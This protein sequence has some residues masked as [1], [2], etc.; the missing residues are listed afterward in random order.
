MLL[1]YFFQVSVVTAQIPLAKDQVSDTVVKIPL[2][3]EGRKR[4]LQK[5]INR[6]DNWTN[7]ASDNGLFDNIQSGDERFEEIQSNLKNARDCLYSDAHS[8]TERYTSLALRAY[9]KS[10]YSSSTKWRFS[11]IYA[12]PMWIYLIGFLIS[13]LIFYCMQLDGT[14]LKL[15]SHIEATA[16][17]ATTWGAVGGILRGLWYLKDKVSDR[18]YRNSFQIYFLSVPFLGALFGALV[19]LLFV[20][21][22]FILIP[23][24]VQNV[25]QN[26]TTTVVN[27]S[28]GGP[29]TFTAQHTTGTGGFV[30]KTNQSNVPNQGISTVG[31]IFFSALGGFNWEWAVTIIKR[32]GDSFK[33]EAEPDE[34]VD[35]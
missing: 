9:D 25:L 18:K 24:Q 19:Y 26:Q 12:G 35:R 23:G 8:D 20:A 33:G 6:I 28:T 3:V 5:E 1:W 16:L 30:N 22:L 11:N 27:K 15:P 32:I 31:I 2:E 7:T 29:V 34:K 14:I 13:S 4:R 17:Y 10:L 21:G